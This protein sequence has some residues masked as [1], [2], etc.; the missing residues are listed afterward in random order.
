VD[1]FGL[2]TYLLQGVGYNSLQSTLC[3]AVADIELHFP[4]SILA[5]SLF[6]MFDALRSTI[7]LGLLGL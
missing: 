3:G 5:L 1:S 2:D 4:V 6:L 7:A